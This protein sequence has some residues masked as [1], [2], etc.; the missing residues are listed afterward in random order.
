MCIPAA[1]PASRVCNLGCPQGR[2]PACL[3]RGHHVQDTCFSVEV[4]PPIAGHPEFVVH[5]TRFEAS[6]LSKCWEVGDQCQVGGAAAGRGLQRQC[7]WVARG[8]SWCCTARAACRRPRG[9]GTA[10]AL[11][12]WS[13]S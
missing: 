1:V 5:R 10:A 11:H 7:G 3:P 12:A 2:L 9:A 8:A 4:P 13:A 6:L